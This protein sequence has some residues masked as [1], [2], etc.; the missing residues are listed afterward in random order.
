VL[1]ISQ[2]GHLSLS[3][4]RLTVLLGLTGLPVVLTGIAAPSLIGQLTWLAPGPRAFVVYAL[5]NCVVL[6]FVIAVA[7][8]SVL[9]GLG[10]RLLVNRPRIQAAVAG[11]MIGVAIYLLVDWMLRQVQI[12]QVGGMN[13]RVLGFSD[14]LALTFSTVLVAPIAEELFFR[15]LWVGGLAP[16]I[17]RWLAGGVSIA[18]FAAIHYS[19]F[20]PGGVIFIAVWSIVPVILFFRFGD[21][22]APLMMHMLNN[23]WAYLGVPLLLR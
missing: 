14:I 9:R 4:S 15:V 3:A 17:G 8:L 7:G 1:P 19:Y 18:A 10:A 5:A 20:G 23:A 6:P 16:R 11:F 12:P 13:F 2:E 22:S 21:I